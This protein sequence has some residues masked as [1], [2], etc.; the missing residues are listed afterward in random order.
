MKGV[1]NKYVNEINSSSKTLDRKAKINY[2]SVNRTNRYFMKRSKRNNCV[3]QK[4]TEMSLFLSINTK[5][6]EKVQ[7]LTWKTTRCYCTFIIIF[8]ATLSLFEKKV[9][10][11]DVS[12][13]LAFAMQ[14]LL[15][16]P[17]EDWFWAKYLS[18]E[19]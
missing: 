5:C 13:I 8:L 3:S 17:E 4:Q 16:K 14:I 11:G 1:Q 15:K 9:I 7:E 10:F 19:L 18:L 2:F 6:L 12:W